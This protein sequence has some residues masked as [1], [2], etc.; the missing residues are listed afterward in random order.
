MN[1][2]FNFGG[3]RSQELNWLLHLLGNADTGNDGLRLCLSTSPSWTKPRVLPGPRHRGLTT[4][5]TPLTGNTKEGK[6]YFVLP[7]RPLY[8]RW[9]SPGAG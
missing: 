9:Y 7:V 2:C 5:R 1:N 4:T 3:T 8:L 6:Q